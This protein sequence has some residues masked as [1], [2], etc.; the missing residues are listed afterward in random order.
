MQ[1]RDEWNAI[2]ARIEGIV[3]A[4]N[5]LISTTLS[6]S[7]GGGEILRSQLSG[8]TYDIDLFR[9]R[10]ADSLPPSALPAFEKLVTEPQSTVANVSAPEPVYLIR[11]QVFPLV[12]F[13]TQMEFL[14]SDFSAITRR[15][16]KRAFLHLQRSLQ[17]DA[18]LGEKW[19]EAFSHE[20]RCEQ[21]GAAHLLQFGLYA[22]K[23]DAFNERTD[24]MLAET[25]VIDDDLASAVDAFV[26]TEWKLV[27][28]GDDQHEK[29]RAARIQAARYSKG[30]A[31]GLELADTRY[32]VLVGPRNLVKI[33]D[34][35]E[36]DIQYKH[37]NIEF[38]QLRP[39][40]DSKKNSRSSK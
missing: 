10:H 6:E 18:S 35:T 1:W 16:S 21:L 22:F 15:R 24:I 2:A 38:A 26:L 27:R 40:D 33:E 20:T 5:L 7:R 39:S 30:A 25:L 4:S 31:L 9:D 34:V 28:P 19:T 36:G 3:S 23:I 8:L 13:R 14:F 37:V 12:L 32:I 11:A 29:A 17:I